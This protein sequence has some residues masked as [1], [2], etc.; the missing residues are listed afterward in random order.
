MISAE[1]AQRLKQAG[2]QWLP[3]ERD[4]FMIPGHQ[5]D[6]QVFVLSQFTGLVQ[7]VNGNPV[8][9]FH[10]TTEWAL[11]YILLAETV[12]L[13]S[14]TQL[15]E[16]IVFMIGTDAP[17]RLDRTPAGYRCQIAVRER[18]LEFDA[19]AAEDAYAQALIYLLQGQQGPTVKT[20]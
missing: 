10:G 7:L 17:M 20:A 2:L 5:L 11:D 3:S 8:I 18:M 1:L 4:F 9:S 14:E 19:A 15:R 16:L 6:N 13:P 12:W